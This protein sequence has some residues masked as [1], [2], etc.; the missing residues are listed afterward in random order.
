M[1]LLVSPKT[2]VTKMITADHVREGGWLPIARMRAP[3]LISP[4][5]P[6]SHSMSLWLPSMI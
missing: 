2:G 6:S 3:L 4:L 5:P 1:T